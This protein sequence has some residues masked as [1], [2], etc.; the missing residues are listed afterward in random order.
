MS[1]AVL[2]R[3]ESRPLAACIGRWN[4]VGNKNDFNRKVVAALKKSPSFL[5]E[6]FESR[7]NR[8]SCPHEKRRSAIEALG[9]KLARDNQFYHQ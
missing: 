9:R 7:M 4:S 5:V 2:A 3:L 8:S 1:A 6:L